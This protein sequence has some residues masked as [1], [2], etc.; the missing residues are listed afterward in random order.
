MGD[1]FCIKCDHFVSSTN[2][3]GLCP[4]CAAEEQNAWPPKSEFYYLRDVINDFNLIHSVKRI[5][6]IGEDDAIRQIVLD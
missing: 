1:L 5:I 6:L 3:D 4:K 2:E